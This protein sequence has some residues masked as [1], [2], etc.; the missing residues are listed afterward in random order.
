MTEAV[1]TREKKPR[2]ET[3]D[4]RQETGD[5]RQDKADYDRGCPHQR[6]QA[7]TQLASRGLR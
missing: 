6:K 4:R 3:G 7:E 2:Q 1:L 5:R